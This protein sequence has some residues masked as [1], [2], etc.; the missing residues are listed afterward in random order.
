MKKIIKNKIAVI[1]SSHLGDEKNN[2]FINHIHKTIG[3]KHDV[4]CYTNYNQYSLTSIY[5]KAIKEYN[6]ENI[7]M[8]FAH[9]D[10]TIKTEN[11]GKILLHRFNHTDFSIIG[12]AG[13]T[14]L[15]DN[16]VW[17]HDRSRMFGIVEHTNG[18]STWVSE[19]APP[20]KGYIKPVVVIDGVFIATDCNN[21][22]HQFDEEFKG[23]HFYEIP[24]CL[25]NYLDEINI[26][27]TTDIRILHNSI[28]MVNEQWELNRQQF[29]EKYKD[30]LPIEYKS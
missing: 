23:Y 27:V 11:F 7:I 26:G 2:E 13:T 16:G 4:I 3:V 15:H 14:Y 8:I 30:E 12:V 6:R 5:N 24:M 20:R 18:I 19:Y 9:P 21:I 1:F 29:I 28:G 10:I 22:I 17:W 25:N